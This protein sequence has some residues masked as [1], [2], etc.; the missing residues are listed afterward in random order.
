MLAAGSPANT[1]L[2]VGVNTATAG[3]KSGTAVVNFATNGSGTS[4]LGT[5]ALAS[6]TVTVSGKVYQPAVALIPSTSIN[7]GTVRVGETVAPKSLSVTNAATAGGLNDVLVGTF[8]GGSSPLTASGNLGTG[9]APGANSGSSLQ[10]QLSTATAGAF[11][12]TATVNL[13]SSNPDMADLPLGSTNINLTGTV[14]N[15]A[16]PV[17]NLTSGSTGSPHRERHCLHSEPRHRH[18]GSRIDLCPP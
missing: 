12:G 14:N 10:A 4:G 1:S 15:W 13:A 9:L 17:F 8:S 7:F 6:Q 11:S 16:N 2:R 5:L 3:S 18:P